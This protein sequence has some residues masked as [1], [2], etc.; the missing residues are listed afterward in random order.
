MVPPAPPLFSTTTGCPS[1]LDKGSCRIRA[2]TSTLPPAGYETI[3]FI[4]LSGYVSAPAVD[5][6]DMAKHPMA[7]AKTAPRVKRP[8]GE[9]PAR[10]DLCVVMIMV[11]PLYNERTGKCPL[12]CDPDRN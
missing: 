8:N 3:R 4:G 6:A 5:I 12:F 7:A 9:R 11:S 2:D 10:R 1:A